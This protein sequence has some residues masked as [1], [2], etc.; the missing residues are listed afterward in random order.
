MCARFAACLL[1]FLSMSGCKDSTSSGT[2]MT[3]SDAGISVS[4]CLTRGE[5]GQAFFGFDYC[6]ASRGTSEARMASGAQ[7]PV[8]IRS[9]DSLGSVMTSNPAI[10][11]VRPGGSMF[12]RGTCVT[13]TAQTA[14][15]VDL[16]VLDSLNRE[17]DRT[18]IEVADATTIEFD[19]GWGP[20]PGPTVLAGTVQGVHAVPKVDAE[21]LVGSGAVRFSTRGSASAASTASAPFPPPY[22][23]NTFGFSGTV[24]SGVIRAE[25]GLAAQELPVT[26]VAPSAI[27]ELRSDTD[28]LKVDTKA[29]Y[30]FVLMRALAGATDV[31]GVECQ[32]TSIPAGVNFTLWK[33]VAL[34]E[35]AGWT[36]VSPGFQYRLLQVV[37]PGTYTA[38]CTV[39]GG[40]SRSIIVILK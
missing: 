22:D 2:G 3:G 30:E 15:R 9:W 31:Y 11:T 36:G 35:T 21:L 27:T 34:T 24:G 4:R 25:S 39:A 26:F 20:A 16:I 37:A 6:E 10:L 29:A 5:N 33:S 12:C 38:T 14:G 40:L 19:R 8:E 18:P 32:W 23:D 28:Q 7:A 13:V 17:F 1:L